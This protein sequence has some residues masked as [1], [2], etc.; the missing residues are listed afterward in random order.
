MNNKQS[1][2]TNAYSL[3]L[4]KNEMDKIYKKILNQAIK[5]EILLS[6]LDLIDSKIQEMG[7]IEKEGKSLKEQYINMYIQMFA[8]VVSY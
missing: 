4:T 8:K 3:T 1:V 5:D 6:K 7:I 2:T